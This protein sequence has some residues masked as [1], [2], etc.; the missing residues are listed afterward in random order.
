MV[1]VG[2]KPV[3]ARQAIAEGFIVLQ[4]ATL[5]AIADEQVPKG[6]VL[7]T[8]RVAGIMAA[9]RCGELI[10]LCHP[11][12]VESVEIAFDRTDP[13]KMRPGMRF[14]GTVEL[15]RLKNTLMI[16]RT[17]VFVTDRGPV[18]Y[19]RGLFSV[20]AVPVKLGHENQEMVQVESGLT[21]GDRILVAKSAAKEP[22]KT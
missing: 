21:A 3:T 16:P 15:S 19:R 13:V 6:E 7:G 10:P 20:D 9:K 2:H 18:T 11:L 22:S 12:P 17:A 5:R 14:K 4:S 1:D 8:A